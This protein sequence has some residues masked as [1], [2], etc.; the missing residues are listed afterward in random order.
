MDNTDD[1]YRAAI[2]GDYQKI[3]SLI[4]AGANFDIYNNHDTS[5][6]HF[7]AYNYSSATTS[8]QKELYIKSIKL[9]IK[10]GVSL[11]RVDIDGTPLHDAC[12]KSAIPVIK[13]LI[14]AGANIN[15]HNRSGNTPLHI[16]VNA[17]NI[18]ALKLLAKAGVDLNRKNNNGYPPIDWACELNRYSFVIFLIE[19]GAKVTPKVIEFYNS[20]VITNHK[21]ETYEAMQNYVQQLGRQIIERIK[22]HQQYDLIKYLEPQEQQYFP[23]AIVKASIKGLY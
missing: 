16:A 14:E 6:L 10:N 2:N 4:K 23:K 21:L 20:L 8:E 7:L 15:A 5:P 22:S 1:I 17:N 13:V 9:L 3:K 11:N 18:E 12:Q 19:S